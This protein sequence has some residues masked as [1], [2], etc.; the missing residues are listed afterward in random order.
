MST[1]IE[2][3]RDEN[4]ALKQKLY[5]AASSAKQY[6]YLYEKERDSAGGK[7]ALRDHDKTKLLAIKDYIDDLLRRWD[8][9]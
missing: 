2:R 3:L 1:E 9:L 6:K 5:S 4:K 8:R 7:A